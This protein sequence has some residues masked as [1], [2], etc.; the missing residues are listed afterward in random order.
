MFQPHLIHNCH[1][2]SSVFSASERY[3]GKISKMAPISHLKH[4]SQWAIHGP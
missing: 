3:I 4:I 1:F 2:F